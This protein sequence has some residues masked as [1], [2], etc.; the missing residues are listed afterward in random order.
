MSHF[1]RKDL[2]R[3]AKKSTLRLVSPRQSV[4]ELS[5]VCV[6]VC[7]CVCVCVCVCVLCACTCD[8]LWMPCTKQMNLIYQRL[9]CSMDGFDGG[10]VYVRKAR[11]RK[12]WKNEQAD[13]KVLSMVF[14]MLWSILR[15]HSKVRLSFHAE[16]YT[17]VALI[18]TSSMC[19]CNFSFVKSFVFSAR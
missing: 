12:R 1:C 3:A 8:K 11:D 10:C 5:R 18:P 2:N 9:W 19:R 13:S 6:C 16:I 15:P 14:Y 7:A 17:A 4:S